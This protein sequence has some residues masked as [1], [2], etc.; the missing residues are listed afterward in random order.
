MND[1]RRLTKK[2][3]GFVF[4]WIVL[5]EQDG[6]K[7]EEIDVNLVS[8]LVDICDL[9]GIDPIEIGINELEIA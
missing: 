2:L 6:C 1:N 4:D 9:A 5:A 3:T 7:L 8:V